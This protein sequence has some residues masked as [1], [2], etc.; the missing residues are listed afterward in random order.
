[1]GWTNPDDGYP[2]LRGSSATHIDGPP[3]CGCGKPL[4]SYTGVCEDC[5]LRRVAGRLPGRV[6]PHGRL[7]EH[8]FCFM[9]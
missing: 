4:K 7:Y 5:W 9:A 8:T 1:M 3:F 6:Q 2:S